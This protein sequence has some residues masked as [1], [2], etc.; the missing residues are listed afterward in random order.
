MKRLAFLGTL[1]L[2]LVVLFAPS[3]GATGYPTGKVVYIEDFYFSPASVSVQPGTTVT[4]VNAGKVPHTV[5]ADSGQFDSGVLM[6]GDSYTV[7]FFGHGTLTYFCAIHPEM[8]GSVGVGV[9][10]TY[11]GGGSHAPMGGRHM[12]MSGGY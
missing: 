10:A 8:R 9:P 2:V 4:W 6:P 11:A 7:K 3:A 12:S 1:T 5:T